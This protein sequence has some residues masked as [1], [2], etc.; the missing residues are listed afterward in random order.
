M[1]AAS[2][3]IGTGAEESRPADS[4]I[5][6]AV[7][8]LFKEAGLSDKDVLEA[9]DEFWRDVKA[10]LACH[11]GSRDAD[12]RLR[13]FEGLAEGSTLAQIKR[14]GAYREQVNQAVCGAAF[15]KL[16][17]NRAELAGIS[18]NTKLGLVTGVRTGRRFATITDDTGNSDRY[19][20]I[21]EQR[22]DGGKK[23]I[24]KN[25]RTG[26]VVEV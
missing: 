9:G 16:R 12:E 17:F 3:L 2:T 22:K 7:Y 21:E 24:I 23:T 1:T 18:K 13:Y 4:R 11:A 19:E 10:G 26:L 6:L 25:T 5:P 20:L 8:T 15:L 14:G